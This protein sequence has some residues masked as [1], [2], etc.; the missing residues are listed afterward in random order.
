MT[1]RS[2]RQIYLQLTAHLYELA[3][4]YSRA[5]LRAAR[6]VARSENNGLSMAAI[7]MLL[8]LHSGDEKKATRPISNH[9]YRAPEPDHKSENADRR[10]A[11]MLK[12]ILMSPELFV[13]TADISKSVPISLPLK[14]KESREKYVNRVITRFRRLDPAKQQEFMDSLQ[15]VMGRN[16]SGSFVSRWSRAIKDL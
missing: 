7:D 13:N 8:A 2:S 15:T 11:R 10:R 9:A 6:D 14:P 1:D 16:S 3:S 4:K 5:E 12:E